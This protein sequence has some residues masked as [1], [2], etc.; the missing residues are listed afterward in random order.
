[1]DVW[2]IATTDSTCSCVQTPKSS[3]FNF[4]QIKQASISISTTQI[5]RSPLILD[6]RRRIFAY[7]HIR[8][9]LA[10]GRYI[11]KLQIHSRQA[12]NKCRLLS[13]AEKHIIVY[14]SQHVRTEVGSKDIC[15]VLHL[16]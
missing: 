11:R 3:I 4:H 6:H 2:W 1:M 10:G 12:S 15:R 13:I 7:S 8:T 9:Q 14:E 5:D 16:C